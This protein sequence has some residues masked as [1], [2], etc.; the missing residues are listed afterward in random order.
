LIKTFLILL[1]ALIIV[2]VSKSQELD[3]QL[4][5]NIL[6]KISV[7]TGSSPEIDGIEQLIENPLH[8]KTATIQEFL[9]IPG[10][11]TSEA[12]N[13][14]LLSKSDSLITFSQLFSKIELTDEQKYLLLICTSLDKF[15]PDKKIFWR[16]RL[17]DYLRE[18]RGFTQNKFKGDKL[19]IYNRF[20]AYSGDF[21][22]GFLTDKD[23]GE[24]H[25][26]D[27]YSVYLSGKVY[28]FKLLAGDYYLET[29]MGNILWKT[30]PAEKGAEVI[31][32]VIQK[33][34]GIREYRSSIDY[35]NFR[36][37]AM[38]RDFKI[39][40]N[41]LNFIAWYSNSERA[42]TYDST[43][44]IITSVYRS[45]YYRTE[46]EI[47]K[48]DAFNEL[49]YGGNLELKG[50][51][52]TLGITALH[53]KND[54]ELV[55]ESKALFMGKEGS[56]LSAYSFFNYS[57]LS[58]GAEFSSDVKGN[59]AFKVGTQYEI[60]NFEIALAG[61][62]FTPG[63]R[64]PYGMIFGE[65]S[66]PN[67]E[68][69]F[70]TGLKYNGIKNILISAYS[71]F[72]A[73]YERT[74]YIP[75]PIHGSDLFFQ[76]EWRIAHNNK[77]LLRLVSENKTDVIAVSETYKEI[78]QKQV[79]RARSEF[80]SK[81]INSLSLRLR[82]EACHIDFQDYAKDETG[83]AGF[84][85]AIWNPQELIQIGGRFSAFST[86]SFESVIYQFELAVPGYM[87]TQPLYGDGFR[88]FLFAKISPV[89]N[90]DLW[91]RYSILKKNNVISIGSGYLEIS[92][93]RDERLMLQ[94]D[95]RL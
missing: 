5:E 63:F 94:L 67:N 48:K 53:I 87:T 73:S 36:G 69:G 76:T 83:I 28:D 77:I 37:F 16:T 24:L 79:F 46:S 92:G 75:E 49:L 56:L 66:I 31:Y 41:N 47:K 13:I 39:F 32:P 90:I 7:E 40:N 82:I 84:C 21:S 74:Y 64:S 2:S 55:T 9:R 22:F 4:L 61:R 12:R 11:T 43:N 14:L 65:S 34:S 89:K 60:N 59:T 10:F 72:Y 86:K 78:F 52:I 33:G 23:A 50:D 93:N 54:K 42:G 57:D 19:D 15:L 95:I 80:E 91:I 38:Q 25:L 8:L 71:D 20:S 27:N 85:E 29:G 88:S 6:E 68:Y 45:G 18:P 26:A 30:F 81:S 51:L 3:F 35:R 70:Y 58:F 1:F 44:D 62:S 17:K